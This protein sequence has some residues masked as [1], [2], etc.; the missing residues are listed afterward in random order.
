MNVN[1]T[2]IENSIS[3]YVDIQTLIQRLPQ[4]LQLAQTKLPD[5]CKLL[6]KKSLTS[7][8]ET[9][10]GTKQKVKECIVNELFVNYDVQLKQVRD[11]PRLYRKTNRSVPNRPCPYLDVVSNALKDFRDDASRKLDDTFLTDLLVALLNAM[12]VT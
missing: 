3:I 7:S 6:L 11:I 2:L 4:F 12:T 8:E 9:L 1:K 10:E 5:D